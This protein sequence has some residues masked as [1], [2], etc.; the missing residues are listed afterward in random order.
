MKRSQAALLAA[1]GGFLF[2]H[3]TGVSCA[4]TCIAP[5]PLKP[6]HRICGIVF[7]PSG[8]RVANAKV[9]VLQAATEIA[10]QK[11]GSDGK[12]SFDRLKAGNYEIRIRIN[13]LG[14]A[15]APIVL[16]KPEAQPKRE[17]AVNMSLTG[18]CSSFSL[19]NSK[20]LEAGLNLGSSF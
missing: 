14:D 20:K 9:T 11:T 6:V 13:G 10:E 18:A 3:A 8:D 2:L 4:T 19:V 7:F 17:I 5:P 1:A 12:F 15:A 16:V